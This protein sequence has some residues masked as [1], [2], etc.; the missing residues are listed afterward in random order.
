MGHLQGVFLQLNPS[1]GLFFNL[2]V[3]KRR[4]LGSAGRQCDSVP[5]LV[6]A[7]HASFHRSPNIPSCCV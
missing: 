4:K 6:Q 3:K 2:Y 5:L 1:L 7:A